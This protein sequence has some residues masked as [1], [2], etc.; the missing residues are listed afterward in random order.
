MGSGMY[1]K[2]QGNFWSKKTSKSC[3]TLIEFLT[4]VLTYTMHKTFL[5]CSRLLCPPARPCCLV[6]VLLA[7]METH[8]FCQLYFSSIPFPHQWHSVH[9]GIQHSQPPSLLLLLSFLPL[10]FCRVSNSRAGIFTTDNSANFINYKPIC[11]WK[12]P[13][14]PGQHWHLVHSAG[15]N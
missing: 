8:L 11:Y 9:F 7:M 4:V 2:V 3:E 10:S 12:P 14:T 1:K 15:G 13:E 6:F 5:F